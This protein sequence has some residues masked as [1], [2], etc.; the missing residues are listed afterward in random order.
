MQNTDNADQAAVVRRE[1]VAV[2]VFAAFLLLGF[3]ALGIDALL[4][5]G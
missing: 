3:V 5:Y 2:W 1:V 4:S